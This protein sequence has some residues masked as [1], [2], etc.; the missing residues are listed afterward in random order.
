[1][2]IDLGGSY[3]LEQVTFESAWRSDS[4]WIP[5]YT[6]AAA[7]VLDYSNDNSTWTNLP[8]VAP[9]QGDVFIHKVPSGVSMRYL[10]LKVVAPA[11]AG[12]Q[13]NISMFRAISYIYGDS[14][15][16][17]ARRLYGTTANGLG[18]VS[19]GSG[20]SWPSWC[21]KPWAPPRPRR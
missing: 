17:D 5:S 2:R 14:T 13:V 18:R 16:I 10:R 21:E 8:S 7:Y 4:R 9:V 1:M 15:R 3:Y 11:T 12:N 6:G 20:S 19:T